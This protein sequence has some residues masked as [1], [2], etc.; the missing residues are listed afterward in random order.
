MIILTFHFV[1]WCCLRMTGVWPVVQWAALSRL[2]LFEAVLQVGCSPF[3][4]SPLHHHTPSV[5][6]HNCRGCC[7]PYLVVLFPGKGTYASCWEQNNNGNIKLRDITLN[8]SMKSKCKIPTP[9]LQFIYYCVGSVDQLVYVYPNLLYYEWEYY[10]KFELKVTF[11]VNTCSKCV[12]FRFR[13]RA[14]WPWW[15]PRFVLAPRLPTWPEIKWYDQ[16]IGINMSYTHS[17]WMFFIFV[18]SCQTS[19]PYRCPT[20]QL[21]LSK[22]VD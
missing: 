11:K 9:I 4:S 20:C 8:R 12:F 13:L 3:V 17:L 16:N 1:S 14:F 7:W 19:I 18:W 2:W 21:Q 6:I 10:N 5:S 22:N 15:P